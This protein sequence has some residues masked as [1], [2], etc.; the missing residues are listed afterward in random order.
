MVVAEVPLWVV[1]GGNSTEDEETNKAKHSLSLYRGRQKCAIYGL[2]VHPPLLATA[3][4]DGTVRI[5]N[6]N[7]LFQGESSSGSKTKKKKKSK[8][9]HFTEQGTYVS[10]SSSGASSGEDDDNDDNHEDDELQQQDEQLSSSSSSGPE[11]AVH[12]LNAVV[13]RKKDG[14]S[15]RKAALPPQ[16]AAATST[17]T[18]TTSTH[19]PTRH[20][21]HKHQ[22][23]QRLLCTLSAH[24]GSSVLA[25][26]FAPSGKYLASAGDD[27]CV[28]IYAPTPGHHHR[29]HWSR[30]KLCRGHA[31]DVVD[32]AWAPD[33]S[34]LVSC[35]LDSE[36]P[37]IVWKLT[38]LILGNKT[39]GS[40]SSMIMNPY[41]ILGVNV[42]TST[43]KGVAFDPAGSYLASSADD[44]AVCIWRAHDDWGLEQR[45][46]ASSGIFRA[47]DGVA[48]TSHQSMFRRLSWSTD[49]SFVCTTNAVVK[50]KHVASTISREGWAVSNAQQAAAGAANLVGHKQP[51]VVSRHAA[52]LL[53]AAKDQPGE[54]PESATL[55]ALGDRKG[56]VTVWS[57]RKS[58]PI[59]KLQCSESR[60]TVTDLSWGKL[61]NGDM[62]LVVSLLDG[63]V[64]ALRFSVPDELGPFLNERDH[65]RV[66]QMRYGIDLQD[67]D[68]LLGSSQRG[69]RRRLLVGQTTGGTELI[70]NALQMSLEDGGIGG[71][72][73][74]VD[75]D[76]EAN[77]GNEKNPFM[78]DEM[79]MSG[80]SS[81]NELASRSVR[82]RQEES[83]GQGGKKRVRPVLMSVSAAEKRQATEAPPAAVAARKEPPADPTQ[84][85][86]NAAEK[87]TAAAADT[88]ATSKQAPAPSAAATK[89]PDGGENV[90]KQQPSTESHHNTAHH[91]ALWTRLAPKIPHSMDRIHTVDLPVPDN[92]VVDD[93]LSLEQQQVNYKAVCTNTSKVPIGSKGSPLPCIDLTIKK[94]EQA[95]WK[96]QI[97]GTSCSAITVSK[98]LLAVGTTDG[99]VQL[100][101]CSPN[102]G[103]ASGSSFRSHPPL[104]FGSAI[105]SLK[106]QKGKDSAVELLVV[107][108][109]GAF[110]VYSLVPSLSLQYK[111]SILPAMTHMATAAS[112]AGGEASLP[113]LS[114]LQVTQSGRLLLLLSYASAQNPSSRTTTK[115]HR[116]VG[117]SLQGFVYD[118]PSELWLR[119]SD[120]RFIL[121][122]FYSSLPSRNARGELSQMDDAVKLGSIHSSLE[123]S[124]RN[125]EAIYSQSET[126]NYLASRSHCEDRMACAVA[127]AS[128]TEFQRWLGWY[129]RTLA[130]AGDATQLRLVV[131]MLLLVPSSQNETAATATTESSSSWW[132][133]SAPTVL[134]LDRKNL[135]K[136]VVLSEMSK[137]RALQRI[138]NEVALEIENL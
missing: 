130:I 62:M 133:S 46:D 27:A 23:Q 10:S 33:D 99:C 125:Q 30:I 111:G 132:L 128:A 131:D 106:L 103:W 92:S 17:T 63:Q 120:S 59:F 31:L 127:L 88:V 72:D 35:S 7:A 45:I 97:P 100:F 41:K 2:D 56:F 19:S 136:T 104:V 69:G 116:G 87:A 108:S 90:Q 74:H 76:G 89:Q 112:L 101:G 114:R 102:R 14:S 25:V 26:R 50:N 52:H 85:A 98:E 34:H 119:V 38:D 29:H 9:A 58:R 121:S 65:A 13:R 47:W 86:L 55:L 11:E 83:R 134:A 123:S 129:V 95:T 96:D 20:K 21:S 81:A 71:D 42:H 5:W 138:T 70:E 84:M 61:T 1:H 57:T 60:C 80:R 94:S 24:T 124:H 36:S 6:T 113:K 39:N 68:S 66:F 79:G 48:S 77:S 4:G 118:R 115:T 73:M 53:D 78:D 43:V 64:V 117:G 40:S 137:N 44:P 122:D 51:V 135:V 126:G 18:T 91:P 15:P 16:T 67:D 49:G 8:S 32:L 3:G 54:E 12:D 107:T 110:G 28:C 93:P 105:V 109:D 75:D 22:Q 37:I 82:D